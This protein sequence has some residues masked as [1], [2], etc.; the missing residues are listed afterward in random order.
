MK[1]KSLFA[2]LALSLMV[3]LAACGSSKQP[4]KVESETKEELKTVRVASWSQPITEQTNL[5][6]SQEKAFYKEQG[7]S[8]TFIPGAGGGDAI[9][10]I[11]TGKADIAFTD[12]GSLYFALDKGEKLRVIYN[13]YPQNVFYVVS[14]IENNIIKPEDL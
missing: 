13:I 5:L 4:Q 3:F 1:G 7:L 12:P 14:L 8:V 11:L 6:V 9:K 10:N 2:V